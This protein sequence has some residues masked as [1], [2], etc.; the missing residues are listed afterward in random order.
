MSTVTI[1]DIAP[2]FRYAVGPSSGFCAAIPFYRQKEAEEFFECV[3][4]ELPWSGARLYRRRF[5]GGIE[6]IAEYTPARATTAG[7]GGK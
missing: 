6:T 5:F 7:E 1:A 3:K 4:R 2:F